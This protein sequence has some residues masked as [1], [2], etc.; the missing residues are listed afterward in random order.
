[1][2]PA[3]SG[4]VVT[5][6]TVVMVGMKLCIRGCLQEE[7]SQNWELKDEDNFIFICWRLWRNGNSTKKEQLFQGHG[8]PHTWE[9]VIWPVAFFTAHILFVYSSQAHVRCRGYRNE[10]NIQYTCPL[11]FTFQVGETDKIEDVLSICHCPA[12]KN[13]PFYFDYSLSSFPKQK[14]TSLA[15]GVQASDLLSS[16]HTH[17]S[18]IPARRWDTC[19]NGCRWGTPL[20]GLGG[21]QGS[22]VLGSV[23]EAEACPSVWVSGVLLGD[24]PESCV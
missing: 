17:P 12:I 5:A 3:P 14:P 18:D 20:A 11:E 19:R 22:M 23:T 15:A 10:Q 9:N 13:I 24:A 7:V 1:M 6:V 8:A 2:K 21:G 4:R 16:S